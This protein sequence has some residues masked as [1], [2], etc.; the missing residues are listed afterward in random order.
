VARNQNYISDRM[1]KKKNFGRNLGL[2]GLG[3]VYFRLVTNYDEHTVMKL[4]WLHQASGL[5]Q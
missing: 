5:Q 1:E 3:T 2:G 4:N